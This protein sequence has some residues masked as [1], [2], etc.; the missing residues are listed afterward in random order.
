[1]NL[2]QGTYNITFSVAFYISQ[3]ISNLVVQWDGS[4][5]AHPPVGPLCP[6]SLSSCDPPSNSQPNSGNG[7]AAPQQLGI[8]SGGTSI[9]RSISFV[10]L[11]AVEALHEPLLNS[12]QSQYGLPPT[13][14]D[15]SASKELDE[16]CSVSRD[17]FSTLAL[18]AQSQN[19]RYR[20]SKSV[21]FSQIRSCARAL[22]CSR[23]LCLV[24]CLG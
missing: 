13:Q 2:P 23:F 19:S 21:S 9:L 11:G 22:M 18:G 15:T 1:L 4:Y 6:I 8:T 10:M 14:I 24:S 20:T 3:T 7:G 17:F 12:R 16:R 5:E